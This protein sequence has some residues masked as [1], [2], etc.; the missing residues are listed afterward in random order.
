MKTPILH[1]Q[2]FENVPYNIS[3]V[4]DFIM[5]KGSV[6]SSIYADSTFDKLSKSSFYNYKTAGYY[7]NNDEL[8]ANHAIQIVGG[9]ITF[10]RIILVR[11]S[12]L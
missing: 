5:K 12:R 2:G 1:V 11:T 10:R 9:T 3:A 8:L 6:V 4:K 7:L